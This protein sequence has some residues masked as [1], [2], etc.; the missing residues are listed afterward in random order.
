MFGSD[1]SLVDEDCSD[2]HSGQSCKS[3]RIVFARSLQLV[4]FPFTS[5]VYNKFGRSMN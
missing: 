3:K 2:H 4:V 5:T 1:A